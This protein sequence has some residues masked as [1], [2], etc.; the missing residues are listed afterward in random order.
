MAD[1]NLAL[2]SLVKVDH[3]ADTNYTTVG[4]TRTITPP[5]RSRVNVDGTVLA[6]TLQTNEP[7]IEAFSTFQ[8]LQLWDPGD[9]NHEILDTL[10][11][12]KTKV[13]WQVLYGSAPVATDTFQGY[14][15]DLAPET[16]EV[17]GIMARVVTV[18]R[19][20]AITRS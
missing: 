8:F 13:N 19:T 4:L 11:G 2:G 1:K 5:G 15:S 12:N 16:L 18:Q 10:F 9:T 6:E 3:D 17:A 14:V 20:G 7:G